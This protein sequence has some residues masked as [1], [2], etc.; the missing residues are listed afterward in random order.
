M[1]NVSFSLE[2]TARNYDRVRAAISK[3]ADH[4]WYRGIIRDTAQ[5]VLQD[6]ARYASSITHKL[7]GQ[8]A[9]AI[10]WD[11]DSHRSEGHVYIN[12][13]IVYRT[14]R[15]TLRWPKIYGKFE[16]DRGG[17]H[18]FFDRTLRDRGHLAESVGMRALQRGVPPA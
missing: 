8:L 4:A 1:P 5:D 7:T 16:H 17:S 13:R 12:E 11:Y 2:L 15:A 14:G 18:A 6:W 3:M 10:T 9:G